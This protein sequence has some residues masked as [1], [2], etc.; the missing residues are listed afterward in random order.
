MIVG[1]GIPGVLNVP[2]VLTVPRVHN[3]YPAAHWAR[4]GSCKAKGSM[5]SHKQRLRS[6]A[7]VSWQVVHAI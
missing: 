1:S 4:T 7:S 2:D 6:I 5:S 3:G